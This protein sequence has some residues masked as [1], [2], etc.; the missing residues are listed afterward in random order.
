MTPA[1]LTLEEALRENERLRAEME[2][3]DG[4]DAINRQYVADLEREIAKLQEQLAIA[5]A[6][7]MVKPYHCDGERVIAWIDNPERKAA[8]EAFTAGLERQIAYRFETLQAAN[9][10]LKAKMGAWSRES[11]ERMEDLA[12]ENAELKERV[13]VARGFIGGKVDFTTS[14][15]VDAD[16]ATDLSKPWKGKP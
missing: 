14:G 12:A 9:E 16:L 10:R 15:W 2:G 6:M 8:S 1:P 11:I 13:A 7:P 5:N 3:I 4:A